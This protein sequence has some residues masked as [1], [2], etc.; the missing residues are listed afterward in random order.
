MALESPLPDQDPDEEVHN[1]PLTCMHDLLADDCTIGSSKNKCRNPYW[2]FK[3]LKKDQEK[4]VSIVLVD[5]VLQP[6][7]LSVGFTTDLSHVDEDM[8]QSLL[9]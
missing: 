1:T 6:I 8:Q 9:C 4:G 2:R 5:V 3:G 7:V